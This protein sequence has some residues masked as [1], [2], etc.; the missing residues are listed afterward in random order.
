MLSEMLQNRV[1][2]PM[3][4]AW[5]LGQFLKAPL[6][7]IINR[8]WKWGVMF[9]AGGFPSTHSAL[10]TCATLSIGLREGFSTALFALSVAIT[11]IVVYDAANVRLEAGK[12]ARLLNEIVTELFEGHQIPEKKLKEVLGHTPVEA[13]S[14]IFLGI[15]VALVYWQLV[16]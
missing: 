8:Q 12:H 4:I 15:T 7:Y 11:M 3:L 2:I 5:L 14:G 16:P 1:L 13:I 10:V 9:S 6:E